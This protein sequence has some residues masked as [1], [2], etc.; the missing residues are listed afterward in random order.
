MHKQGSYSQAET[1]LCKIQGLLKDSPMVVKD[2]KFMKNTDFNL[3]LVFLK[4]MY[5]SSE[6]LDRDNEEISIRK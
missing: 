6:M 1:T 2:Y 3:C 4:C 5:L